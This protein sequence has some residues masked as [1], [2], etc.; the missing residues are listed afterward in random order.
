MVGYKS[1]SKIS[2]VLEAL[3][4]RIRFMN[5]GLHPSCKSAYRKCKISLYQ[6]A[7]FKEVTKSEINIMAQSLSKIYI[8]CVFGTKYRRKVLLEEDQQRIWQYIAGV[9]RSLKCTPIQIG[10]VEDH[11]HILCSISR[12]ISVAEFMQKVKSKSSK[13]IKSIGVPYED[14]S[15]QRGYGCFSVSERHSGRVAKYILNQKQHHDRLSFEKDYVRLLDSHGIE[16]DV[17]FLWSD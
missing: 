5:D 13:W 12:S 16:N 14:F 9:I 2:D 6:S 17:Q 7:I 10:G 15:W 8:H 4:L 1:H 3:R 11:I